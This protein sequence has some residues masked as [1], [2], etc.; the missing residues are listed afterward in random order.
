[1]KTELLKLILDFIG[2]FL[3]FIAIDYKRESNHIE[4]LSFKDSCILIITILI[5]VL[6][7]KY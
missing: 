3:I 7:L 6:L 4:E 5:A 2:C 1:M